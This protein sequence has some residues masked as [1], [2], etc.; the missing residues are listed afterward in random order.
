M[1]K[2]W[3]C[4]MTSAGNEKNLREMIEPILEY[5]DGLVWTFHLPIETIETDSAGSF[6]VTDSGYEFLERNKKEG[7]IVTAEWCDRHGYGMTHYLWQ[8]PMQEG[9]FFVQLDS[10]ERL[11]KEFAAHLRSICADMEEKNIGMIA[12]KGKG[13]IFRYN[14]LLEFRGSP[15]WS[16]INVIGQVAQVELEENEFWNVRNENRDPFHFV[17]HYLKY[18]L[19]PAGSN[20]CLLGLEKNGDP[21]KLFPE[22]EER[23][24]RFKKYLRKYEIPLTV[25]GV[26]NH[27]Q[28]QKE[29]PLEELLYFVNSEKILND[30][31]RYHV[32][33]DHDFKDDHDFENMVK[34]E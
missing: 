3:L 27:L 21:Q 19:Y 26:I 13:L 9:D 1:S 31:W 12:H 23:R 6:V 5:F 30:A 18:Y 28:E 25:E 20:H 16:P 15:H 33:N 17:N 7:K 34:I 11:G 24:L 4:G 2:L 22:R 32:L 14:E 8:G 29:K 10:T